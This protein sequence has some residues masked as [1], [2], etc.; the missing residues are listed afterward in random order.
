MSEAFKVFV[1]DDDAFVLDIIRGILEPACEVETFDSVES[2][3]PR[4]ET[5]KPDMFLLDVRMPGIDGYAFCRQIKDDAGLRH[6]PVTFVSGQD[7]IDARLKGYDAGGEDFI[8]KPFQAEEVLR[9]VKIAQQIA[10]DKRALTSQLEDSELLSSLVM[11]NMDEYAILVRFMR[12]LISWETEQEIAS[13]I[14]DMLRRYRLDGVV[15]TRISQRTLTLSAQGANLPLEASILSHVKSM[16]RIFEFRNRSVH[17]FERLTMMINNLPLNDPDY[18]GRLRDHLCIAAEAAEARL[19]AIETEEANRRSQTGIQSA[20]E[21]VRTM[22]ASLHQA[23]LRD[24]ATSSEL[25]VRMEQSLSNAFVHLGMSEDQERHLGDLVHRFMK[26]LVELLDRGEE[27]H[28]ALQE[29]G[30]RLGQLTP[31][32]GQK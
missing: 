29:L 25:F 7:T 18:C 8:V 24:R 16:D 2:C 30:E 20:L 14:L 9:K 3:A 15:Q 21:R 28:E 22:T 12:E 1:V 32:T 11:A 17:N 4:L 6:I 26:E 5:A 27:T 19:R 31:G 13:G 23:H 10:R